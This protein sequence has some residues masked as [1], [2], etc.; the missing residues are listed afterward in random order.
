MKTIA[1]R[2]AQIATLA[3][4]ALIFTGAVPE[5]DRSASAREVEQLRGLVKS[6]EKKV[7]TLE[8]RIHQMENRSYFHQVPP[9]HSL[10]PIPGQP[11]FVVP[12]PKQE[13][14]KVWGKGEFNGW[15]YYIIPVQ[16]R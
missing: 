7:A 6:L 3:V 5:D 15:P 13:P 2:F 4:A 11:G 8:G 12:L 14:P 1:S 16:E 10:P 9:S